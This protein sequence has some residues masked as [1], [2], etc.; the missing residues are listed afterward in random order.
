MDVISNP[1]V[2]SNS[3]LQRDLRNKIGVART[4]TVKF[5]GESGV[6]SNMSYNAV[7]TMQRERANNQAQSVAGA[8]SNITGIGQKAAPTKPPAHNYTPSNSNFIRNKNIDY[9]RPPSAHA[10]INSIPN[11]SNRKHRNGLSD[12]PMGYYDI[13]KAM[14]KSA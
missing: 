8:K 11:V 4:T 6:T 14:A 2:A 10:A 1:T 12:V 7:I 3:I 13:D 9:T 5:R